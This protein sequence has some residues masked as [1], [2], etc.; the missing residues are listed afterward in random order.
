M[1]LFLVFILSFVFSLLIHSIFIFIER[2][3]RFNGRQK[4]YNK[5]KSG[6]HLSNKSDLPFVKNYISF[7]KGILANC[8][9]AEY[10]RFLKYTYYYYLENNS[11]ESFNDYLNRTYPPI[12]QKSRK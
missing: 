6:I 3:L 1:N 10:E 11:H 2:L 12:K 7:N 4:K 5:I 8:N 9:L